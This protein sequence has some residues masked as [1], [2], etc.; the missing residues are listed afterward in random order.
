MS[1]LTLYEIAAEHRDMVNKLMEICDDPQVIADTIE[2]ESLSLEVKA[3]QV[4]FASRNLRA[5][6]AS[7]HDAAADMTRRADRIERHAERIDAYLLHCMQVSG[8]QKIDCPYFEMALRKNPPS[9]DV[10]EP[11][12]LPPE[13][14]KHPEPPAP[15][16]NKVAIAKAIK[17]GKEVPGARLKPGET[18]LEIK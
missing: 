2:G 13:Y 5:L 16:P 7:I 17:A 12:L 18:R 4:A 10:F 14:M 15:T 8:K 11:G 3:Q 9:V 6:A 1:D